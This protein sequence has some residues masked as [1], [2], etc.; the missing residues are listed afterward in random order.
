[1]RGVQ[2]ARRTFMAAQP[3]QRLAT[4]TRC[5]A[6][7]EP[8]QAE[9]RAQK[10]A[11]RRA[12]RA[13]LRAVC[14][15]ALEEDSACS[16]CCNR[17][18]PQGSAALLAPQAAWLCSDC[19]RQLRSP[20][21]ATSACMSAA[22]GCTKWT[23]ASCCVCCYSQARQAPPLRRA[24]LTAACDTPAVQGQGSAASP[25]LLARARRRWSFTA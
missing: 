8:R 10:D 6:A 25:H 22:S 4:D 24:G 19:W 5:A 18:R 16:D 23:R 9:L 20:Q 1:M 7:A 11:A 21:A 13:T 2:L 15:N 3:A 17:A 12:M 14:K